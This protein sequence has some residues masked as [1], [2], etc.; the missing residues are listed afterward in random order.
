ML[1]TPTFFSFLLQNLYSIVDIFW[2]SRLGTNAIAAVSLASI[3]SFMVFTLSQTIA[4]GTTAYVSQF[5]GKGNWKSIRDFSSQ[6]LSL[7]F[8]GGVIFTLIA[9]AF[10]NQLMIIM[11]GKGEVVSLGSAYIVY[12]SAFIPFFMLNFAVNAVFRATGDT[13]TPMVILMGSNILNIILDP[14]FI[15][16][17]K[18]GVKGAALATGISY[19]LAFLYGLGKLVK[20]LEA[21]TFEPHKPNLK[22]GWKILKVGIPSGIQFTIM[23]LTIFIILRIVAGYGSSVIAAVGITGRLMQFVQIPILS[24]AIS[25]SIVCGQ[26]LGMENGKEAERTVKKTLFINEII[27]IGLIIIIFPLAKELMGIFSKETAV[28]KNGVALLK[29]FIIARI[30][31]SINITISSSFR[32]SGDTMPPLYVSIGRIIFLSALAPIL[33]HYFGL[34]GIWASLVVSSFLSSIISITFFL[35]RDWKAR[36]VTRKFAMGIN[37]G[38]QK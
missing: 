18:L 31:V 3:L 19:T 35:K 29:F 25:S 28:V 27:M 4:V 9:L 24:L 1:S 38:G 36:A 7:S 17:L 10:P 11:G 32:A 2:I 34:A 12:V 5:K 23:S 15:F 13:F 8:Y 30:F 26:Y 21:K 6:S 37:S 14:I 16:T 22:L 20:F 33:A